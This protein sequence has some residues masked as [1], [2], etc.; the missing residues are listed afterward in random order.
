MDHTKWIKEGK[1]KFFVASEKD[2]PDLIAFIQDNF[3]SYEPIMRN[4]G[5]MEGKGTLDRYLRK[6]MCKRHVTDLILKSQTTP[7]C[8]VARSTIDDSILGCRMGEIVNRK[9]ARSKCDQ[10][11]TCILPFVSFLPIPLKSNHLM[12][13]KRLFKDLKYSQIDAFRELKDSDKIYF[14]AN[15]CVSA[16]SRGLGLGS[17]LVRRGYSIAKQSGC[18][19]TYILA[20]SMYSQNKFHK[21]GNCQI[22]HQAKYKDYRFDKHGRPFLINTKEHK[23]IQ[24]VAIHHLKESSYCY[25]T[26]AKPTRALNHCKNNFI[27]EEVK[28][29]KRNDDKM[30]FEDKEMRKSIEQLEIE[31]T[32]LS[33]KVEN[34]EKELRKVRKNIMDKNAT[35]LQLLE[36]FSKFT[37]E[38]ECL[39][40]VSLHH[41]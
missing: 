7:A 4:I 8:I 14:A 9:Q 26:A 31:K 37:E 32:F 30:K 27:R 17:E 38:N 39:Q 25:E 6:E 33:L 13:M 34:L 16:K 24:V 3:F 18:D 1:L 21:L 20:S 40:N 35:I 28:E 19:Y 29:N 12:N 15:V 41:S 5:V 23:V 10:P 22:L 36:D 2:I 11:F